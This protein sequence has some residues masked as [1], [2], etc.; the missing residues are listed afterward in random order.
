MS[1]ALPEQRQQ[2]HLIN[3]DL[4][5]LHGGAVHVLQQ[6]LEVLPVQETIPVTVIPAAHDSMGIHGS[7]QPTQHGLGVLVTPTP[8]YRLKAGMLQ[9]NGDAEEHEWG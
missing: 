4:D 1:A 3:I 9:G 5:G 8:E 2:A 7:F 6:A